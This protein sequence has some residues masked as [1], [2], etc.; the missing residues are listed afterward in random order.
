MLWH[1]LTKELDI[2]LVNDSCMLMFY[3]V[4]IFILDSKSDK[5]SADVRDILELER[6]VTPELNRDSLLNK[7]RKL[8]IGE[9]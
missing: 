9:M 5:M 1:N 4:I 7:Q 6:P 8:T 3:V 2:H